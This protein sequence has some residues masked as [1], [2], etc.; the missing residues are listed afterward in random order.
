MCQALYLHYLLSVPQ[1]A[2][3]TSITD[4]EA[5]AQRGGETCLSSSAEKWQSKNSNIGLPA[6]LGWQDTS[7]FINSQSRLK[8]R[9]TGRQWLHCYF[10]SQPKLWD[11]R[12]AACGAVHRLACFTCSRSFCPYKTLW[13]G[14]IIYP[15]HRQGNKEKGEE[16]TC[17]IYKVYRGYSLKLQVTPRMGYG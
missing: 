15:F 4:E 1:K 7:Y 16:M 10:C 17:P 6:Y 14:A 8:A 11:P 9:Q 13:S 2:Q 5:G 12:L 3:D